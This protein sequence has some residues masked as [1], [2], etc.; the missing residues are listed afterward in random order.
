VY[1]YETFLLLLN[2]KMMQLF[3]SMHVP[4]HGL[5]K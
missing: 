5:G 2:V 3:A 4:C 1:G